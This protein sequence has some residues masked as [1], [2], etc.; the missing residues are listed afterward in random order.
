MTFRRTIARSAA[1][2]LI[3]LGFLLV[4]AA[5]LRVGLRRVERAEVAPTP[6][7]LI[8]ILNEDG[9]LVRD[10][11]PIDAEG[12]KP[13][14][15]GRPPTVVVRRDARGAAV[16]AALAGLREAGVTRVILREAEATEAPR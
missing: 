13:E 9:R 5:G 15:S 3:V 6:P 16:T 12:V 8:L 4:A 1:P 10:G 2:P 11:R 7:G 14:V